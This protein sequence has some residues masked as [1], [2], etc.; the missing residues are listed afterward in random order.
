MNGE[1]ERDAE[2]AEQTRDREMCDPVTDAGRT[3]GLAP[4]E[5]EHEFGDDERTGQQQSEPGPKPAGAPFDGDRTDGAGG[6]R[7]DG[8]D[9]RDHQ[10][11]HDRERRTRCAQA[12]S[13]PRWAALQRHPQQ[14]D[15]RNHDERRE[16]DG[17]TANRDH[18]A[19]R[20]EFRA[21]GDGHAPNIAWYCWRRCCCC[22]NNCVQ[23][24]DTEMAPGGLA[25]PA[26]PSTTGCQPVEAI[27][28]C[29]SVDKT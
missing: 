27:F 17:D 14:L 2:R 26:T 25:G 28:C 22:P 15:E 1:D 18:G 21:A 12:V 13:Y 7:D 19:A 11:V 8:D 16:R 10:C 24:G 6:H 29:P 3:V 4:G 9:G 23:S 5:A 20:L